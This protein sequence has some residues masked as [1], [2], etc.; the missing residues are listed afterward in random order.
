MN[1][2]IIGI[3]LSLIILTVVVVEIF[4]YLVP[5]Q[6]GNSNENETSKQNNFLGQP[7]ISNVQRFTDNLSSNA[8]DNASGGTVIRSNIIKDTIIRGSTGGTNAPLPYPRI[9]INYTIDNIGTIGDKSPG[10]NNT[11]SLVNLDI[12]NYGYKYFDAHPTKFRLIIRDKTFEPIVNIS[13]GS[14]IDAVIPNNS[15]AKGD[16]VFILRSKDAQARPKITY[17]GDYKIVYSYGIPYEGK[18]TPTATIEEYE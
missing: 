7:G 11:F 14:V 4:A 12:R 9:S 10:E 13:T 18:A 2:K 3:I 16:L 17:I 5:K 6:P 15:R 8:S 1:K